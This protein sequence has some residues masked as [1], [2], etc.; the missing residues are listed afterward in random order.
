MPTKFIPLLSSRKLNLV[1]L[2]KEFCRR[3]LYSPTLVCAACT[4]NGLSRMAAFSKRVNCSRQ[5]LF[6]LQSLVGE[7]LS[8]SIIGSLAAI[9]VQQQQQNSPS[10]KL[11]SPY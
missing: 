2:E 1:N 5:F 7:F 10:H 9:D 4:V 11:L 8:S 3:R 6:C